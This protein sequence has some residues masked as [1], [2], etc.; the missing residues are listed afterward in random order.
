M[1]IHTLLSAKTVT[2]AKKKGKKEARSNR[3]GVVKWQVDVLWFSSSTKNKRCCLVGTCIFLNLYIL[4]WSE[5]MLCPYTTDFFNLINKINK[6]NKIV[7]LSWNFTSLNQNRVLNSVQ[8][9]IY[10]HKRPNNFLCWWIMRLEVV[11]MKTY[12]TL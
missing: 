12:F 3:S 9:C 2:K 1:S 10:L 11:T 4:Y 5:R 6:T 7:W 8:L